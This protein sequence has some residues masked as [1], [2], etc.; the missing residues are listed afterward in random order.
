MLGPERQA[1]S[2]CHLWVPLNKPALQSQKVRD[3][4]HQ[5][6]LTESQNH[7]LVWVR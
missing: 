2:D 4:Q 1:A 6:L 3:F 5:W 7:T